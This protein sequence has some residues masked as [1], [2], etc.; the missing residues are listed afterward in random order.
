MKSKYQ[1]GW[2]H[3]QPQKKK[4]DYTSVQIFGSIG[5]AIGAI[6]VIIII[7]AIAYLYG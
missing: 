5:V 7:S 3:N 2:L 4:K 6:E 1:L